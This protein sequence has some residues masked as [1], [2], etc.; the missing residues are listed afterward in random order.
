MKKS[1]LSLIVVWA[2]VL[3]I[4]CWF[5]ISI[6]K[7]GSLRVPDTWQLLFVAALLAPGI[8][9]ALI[10]PLLSD[11]EGSNSATIEFVSLNLMQLKTYMVGIFLTIVVVGVVVVLMAAVWGLLLNSFLLVSDF[12]RDS[13]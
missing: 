11:Y 6:Y 4:A 2:C 5:A 7:G 3:A 8:A 10:S 1:A 13:A 12:F 9:F